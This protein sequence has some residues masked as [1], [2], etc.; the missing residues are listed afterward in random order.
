MKHLRLI[1]SALIVWC[2]ALASAW[3]PDVL[4]QGFEMCR[5][6]QPDDY[7]GAVQSTIIRYVPECA[8]SVGVL[9]VHGYNDYFF[10]REMAEQFA[11][12]CYAFYAVDLRKYGR[13]IMDG[14]RPFEVRKISEYYADIDSALCR[15]RADGI[16]NIVLMGHSTGGL[17]TSAYLAETGVPA[18]IKA[19]VLN[20][21][22]LDWN[23]SKF[24]EKFLIPMVR[25]VGKLLPRINI[26]QDGDSAYAHSLLKDFDGE[27]D[28][29]TDWK[30]IN[31]PAVTSAWIGAIDAAHSIVQHNPDLQLPIL[32]MH[33]DRSFGKNSPASDISC[34]DAVLDVDDISRYGR[35]LGPD[36]TEL[37][38]KGGLHDLVLSAPEVRYPLY[39]SIFDFL[40]RVCPTH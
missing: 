17:I 28:Y 1:I 20:S 37:T 10:Q 38:V 6:Q 24:Q 34:T 16:K 40:S 29:N 22:F 33:S 19:L 30:M 12:H 8:D 21:P 2:G 26:P 4:G 39:E 14:Q 32:L 5:V 35:Q 27:W 23:Q 18:D 3:Q 25:G 15:M 13:S 11:A 31:S 7:S 9:Y 36:V